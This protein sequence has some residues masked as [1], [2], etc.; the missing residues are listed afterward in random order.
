MTRPHMLLI[1]RAFCL[2][3]IAPRREVLSP[4]FEPITFIAVSLHGFVYDVTYSRLAFSPKNKTLPPQYTV[5]LCT[6]YTSTLPPH[7]NTLYLSPLSQLKPTCCV[8]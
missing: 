1:G 8:G 2:A 4:F 7:I 6:Y 5:M 3:F